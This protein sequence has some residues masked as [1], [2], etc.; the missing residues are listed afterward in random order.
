VV[1]EL[2][3]LDLCLEDDEDEEEEPLLGEGLWCLDLC[4]D[5]F[6]PLISNFSTDVDLL[7]AA[8]L[9]SDFLQQR[10]QFQIR[11]GSLASVLETGGLWHS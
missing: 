9:I 8:L 6:S 7:L 3:W 1:E 5:D 11:R 10:V 2:E 4:F